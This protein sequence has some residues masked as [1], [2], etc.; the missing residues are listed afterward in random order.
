[1][2]DR[3]FFG[4]LVQPSACFVNVARAA[5]AVRADLVDVL[6]RRWFAGAALDVFEDE[7][8]SGG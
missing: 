8:L 1:M 5:C 3:R 2:F 4:R 6:E 7:P